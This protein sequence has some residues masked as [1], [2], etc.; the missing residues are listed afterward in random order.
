[1]HKPQRAS[2]VES[3]HTSGMEAPRVETEKEM[4]I[5]CLQVA[6]DMAELLVFDIKVATVHLWDD[7]I[8][9][10]KS[11]ET[12]IE[13]CHKFLSLA[14]QPLHL[15]GA[16][17]SDLSDVAQKCLRQLDFIANTIEDATLLSVSGSPKDACVLLVSKVMGAIEI[18][19][20]LSA[21]FADELN[22]AEA[23]HEVFADPRDRKTPANAS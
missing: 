5:E 6:Q 22:L 11:L 4:A 8:L 9:K 3:P 21:Q 7:A 23:G 17:P 13:D 2:L 18:W 20:G 16:S 15:L 12:L 19:I 14:A 1:M 10:N